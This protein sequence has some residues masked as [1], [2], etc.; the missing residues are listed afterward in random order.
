M[1]GA[2]RIRK[3]KSNYLCVCKTF[4][5]FQ[6]D[7]KKWTK[8]NRWARPVPPPQGAATECHQFSGIIKP[9]GF[10]ERAREVTF[11]AM[12]LLHNRKRKTSSQ[13]WAEPPQSG[14][15][16]RGWRRKETAASPVLYLAATRPPFLLPHS[17]AMTC[18]TPT[19][20][21]LTSN[22]SQASLMLA[23]LSL[24]SAFLALKIWNL[25]SSKLPQCAFP[26]WLN[27]FECSHWDFLWICDVC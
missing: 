13:R 12:R 7:S 15:A 5:S 19:L 20:S 14:L 11:T 25:E 17:P 10:P 6:S 8:I 24:V 23:S 22:T 18:C 4:L 2:F 3:N 26:V 9:W 1:C 21:L 27:A 16:L